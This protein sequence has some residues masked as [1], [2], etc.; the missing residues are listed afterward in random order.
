MPKQGRNDLCRCRSGKKYKKCCLPKDEEVRLQAV[1]RE[2]GDAT[3]S[4]DRNA[5]RLDDNAP[6]SHDKDPLAEARLDYLDAAE[7]MDFAGRR[8]MFTNMLVNNII[9]R[10]LAFQMAELLQEAAA[11]DADRLAV[12]ECIEELL[13]RFP[14]ITREDFIY[15]ADFLIANNLAGGRLDR[16]QAVYLEAAEHAGNLDV[17][18]RISDRLAYHGQLAAL[19]DGMRL[20]WPIV[21][22]SRDLLEWAID[23]FGG[24]L[25]DYEAFAYVDARANGTEEDFNDL[26]K[27]MEDGIEGID[28]A[29]L[30][31]YLA[32]IDNRGSTA[33]SL[34]ELSPAKK[35]RKNLST[36]SNEFLGYLRRK[37][38]VP[39]TKGRMAAYDIAEYLIER[40]DG[41]LRRA[42]ALTIPFTGRWPGMPK[43]AALLHILCPDADTLDE[44]LSRMFDVFS[45]RSYRAGAMCEFI[46]AWLRFLEAKGLLEPELSVRVRSDLAPMMKT[47]LKILRNASR[48]P[49][50]INAGNILGS[51]TS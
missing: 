23:E 8:E 13:R 50:L 16:V 12:N 28:V 10:D 51:G 27:R 42:S 48:D 30:K 6:S 4:R 40:H 47:M 37:E 2:P 25:S 5:A 39:Y 11:N 41:E 49:A 26:V 22:K 17:F 38:S 18:M 45:S 21:K 34:P 14:N 20:A 35:T 33:W 1:T 19:L 3:L 29:L 24:L 32:C 9:S 43:H 46:P 7:A 15:Y 36:F 31:G 44:Y